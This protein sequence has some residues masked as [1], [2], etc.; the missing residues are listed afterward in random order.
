MA[1]KSASSE[2]WLD[3]L[4]KINLHFGRFASDIGGVFSLPLL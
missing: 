4:A 1:K 2:D 3:R